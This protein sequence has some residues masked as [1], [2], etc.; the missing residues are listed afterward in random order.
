[1]MLDSKAVFRDRADAMGVTNEEMETMKKQGWYTFGRLAFACN[2]KQST[3]GLS[4]FS[5]KLF[6]MR[7]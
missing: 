2:Y 1:M 4:A 6:Y 7:Y 3:L 5:I